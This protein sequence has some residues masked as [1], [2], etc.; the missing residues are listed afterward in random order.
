[1]TLS[2]RPK[3]SST[4]RQALARGVRHTPASHPCEQVREALSRT[5]CRSLNVGR[6]PLL[7]PRSGSGRSADLKDGRGPRRA[8]KRCAQGRRTFRW[9]DLWPR[10]P[11][12]DRPTL[13]RLELVVGRSLFP[14]TVV[15]G[16]AIA[17][18]GVLALVAA[19]C[20][21]GGGAP[22]AAAAE[23]AAGAPT[24]VEVMLSEFEIDPR[25]S[26]RYRSPI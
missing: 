15:R 22:G 5:S 19:A 2:P 11:A 25:R 9:R 24:T 14:R 10:Q 7:Y 13:Y 18:L 8:S 17:T 1:M 23:Q 6:P 26:G 21:G 20:D 16:R 12:P 3:C 4:C